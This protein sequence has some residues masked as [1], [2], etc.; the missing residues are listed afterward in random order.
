VT[1]LTPEE[2][3]AVVEDYDTGGEVDARYVKQCY[4]AQLVATRRETR[5]TLDP[6]SFVAALVANADVDVTDPDRD[7]IK[8][9]YREQLQSARRVAGDPRV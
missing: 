4:E 6:Q 1:A 7:R 8:Q 5:D 9:V 3:L 2:F